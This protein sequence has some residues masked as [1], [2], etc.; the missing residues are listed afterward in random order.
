MDA[1][2]VHTSVLELT[3]IVLAPTTVGMNPSDAGT[4]RVTATSYGENK[5]LEYNYRSNFDWRGVMQKMTGGKPLPADPH[6]QTG[7]DN[8]G[9]EQLFH[10]AAFGLPCTATLQPPSFV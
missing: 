10:C 9:E 3:G 4:E 5:R 8:P 2:A 6:G 7:P 1:D